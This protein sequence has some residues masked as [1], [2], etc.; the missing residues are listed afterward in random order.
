MTTLNYGTNDVQVVKK[1]SDRL[2]YDITTDTEI[3]SDAVSMGIIGTKDD[4]SKGAGDQVKFHFIPFAKCYLSLIRER[5][6]HSG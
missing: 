2:Y 6:H 1:W 5:L 3:V 4:L